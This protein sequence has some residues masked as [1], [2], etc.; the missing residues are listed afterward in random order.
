MKF[1][2]ITYFVHGSTFDNENNISSGWN[3]VDLSK[4]GIE[5]SKKLKELIIGKN[6][7]LIISSD[8]KRAVHTSK[9]VFPKDKI[10]IDKR[11]RECNYGDF[12]LIDSEFMDKEYYNRI[13]KPFPNGESLDDVNE[14]LKNL[15]DEL[16]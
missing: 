6:F 2:K 15:L 5:Q 16:I 10:K 12:T 3:D 11:L 13:S 7:D 1:I 14:R 9:I 8:L 4:L